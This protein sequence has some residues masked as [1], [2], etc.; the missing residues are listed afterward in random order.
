MQKCYICQNKYATKTNSHII[1][2]FLVAKICSYDD[3]GKRDRDVIFSFD[4]SSV[5]LYIGQLPSTKIDELLDTEKITDERIDKLRC[6]PVAKDF[7]F[8]PECE[9]NLGDL[10]EAPY[11][12]FIK[13][14]KSITPDIAYFFW[15]SVAFRISITQNFKFRLP[16]EIETNL[17]YCLNNYMI[18]RK[19]GKQV[20]DIVSK[21]N[22]S[23]K[24]LVCPDFLPANSAGMYAE[25]SEEFKILT[26]VIG[27]IISIFSFKN[28]CSK[29]FR[30]FGIENAIR[31][32]PTNCGVEPEKNKTL[33]IEALKNINSQLIS[34]AVKQKKE[35]YRKFTNKVWNEI[36]LQ[37]EMPKHMFNYFLSSLCG[38]DVKLG[39]R[40]TIEHIHDVFTKTLSYFGYRPR[41]NQ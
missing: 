13:E 20:A 36:G 4:Y 8:C 29:K 14:G 1:P 23:Y 24:L 2:S 12:Q 19:E 17:G 40:H 38:E 34:K 18:A 30:F 26:I 16:Q 28:D 10:I 35:F 41:N 39:E 25:Y 33:S 6:N 31:R 37:G 22:V 15:I 3:S 21:C 27:D 5:N 32:A 7:I 9:K 11:A